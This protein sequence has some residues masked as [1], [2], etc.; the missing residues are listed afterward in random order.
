MGIQNTRTFDSTVRL[1]L[2][3]DTCGAK[4]FAGGDHWSASSK[5]TA[6]NDAGANC[7]NVFGRSVPKG[8]PS[9]SVKVSME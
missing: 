4:Y 7:Q 3:D 6:L 8:K 9:F 5:G 1:W 2:R